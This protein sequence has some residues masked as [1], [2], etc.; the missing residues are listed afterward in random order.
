MNAEALAYTLLIGA[1]AGWI[2]GLIIKGKG[3][4]LLGNI[5]IGVIGALLGGFLFGLV[6]I[7]ATNLLGRL[8]FAVIGALIFSQLLRYV[9]R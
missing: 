2:S 1:L 9:K 8:I 5:I 6:G 3:F 4:G 7:A